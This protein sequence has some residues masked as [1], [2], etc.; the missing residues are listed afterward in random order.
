MVEAAGLCGGCNKVMQEKERFEEAKKKIIGIERQRLGIGT[1]SEK[2]VHAIFK[3]YYEPDE[4]KQEIP[5]NRY[6]ADIFD[7]QKIIEIQ[8]RQFNRMREKLE[9]FLPLYPVTIVYPI[10]REKWLIWIDED[11][12]ELSS[13]RKSPKKG[14]IYEAF[15][16]L[17]KIK[18]FLKDPNLRLK[19]VLVDMEEYRLLNGWSRDRKKGSSR[20]DRIPMELVGEVDVERA[21]DYMQFV[22]A[23]LDGEFTVKD[24]AKEA[25]IPQNLA[26]TVLNI[27][28]YMGTVDRVGKQGNAYKYCVREST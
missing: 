17:Y 20:F 11:S 21:E 26:G 27:L 13:R 15:I 1:Y 25:H 16:E 22:P 23:Q 4:D 8:T 10:P 5:I 6:V 7:G 24:F 14:K 19:I 9:V 18:M 28:Y 2:T 12:G 3:N